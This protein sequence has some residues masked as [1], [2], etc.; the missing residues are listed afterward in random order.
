MISHHKWNDPNIGKMCIYRNWHLAVIHIRTL[1]HAIPSPRNK[2]LQLLCQKP[3]FPLQ[4]WRFSS[5]ILKSA[6][7]ILLA[8]FSS[9]RTNWFHLYLIDSL[10]LPKAKTQTP[11]QNIFSDIQSLLAVI[12]A[13]LGEFP[14]FLWQVL[15][16][17]RG[18]DLDI[19]GKL[20]QR[21]LKM[22][23]WKNMG[24]NNK[25]RW[26]SSGWQSC[27]SGTSTIFFWPKLAIHFVGCLSFMVVQ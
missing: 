12:L 25:K 8:V 7:I 2:S 27:T 13:G 14:A 5:W 23:E 22:E 17:L 16:N 6:F 15:N 24:K 19:L 26:K 11:V 4:I 18:S 9:L 3:M 10:V 21:L 20:L 1:S